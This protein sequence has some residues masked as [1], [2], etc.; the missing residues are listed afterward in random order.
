MSDA[1][2]SPPGLSI[3]QDV[4]P[5]LREALIKLAELVRSSRDTVPSG[6][7]SSTV[8][9]DAIREQLDEIRAGLD[10]LG[11]RELKMEFSYT[12][13]AVQRLEQ[14]T[15]L[16]YP[17][18][19]TP[20]SLSDALFIERGLP[21]EDLRD[22]AKETARSLRDQLAELQEQARRTDQDLER[23]LPEA[24]ATRERINDI[25]RRYPER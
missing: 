1:G 17:A 4:P 19:V 8:D 25:L 14:L 20:G 6:E 23:V 7:R 22:Y 13:L 3:P 10:D 21:V 24:R 16:L 9:L 2:E 12:L 5:Q 18:G 15:T 11:R